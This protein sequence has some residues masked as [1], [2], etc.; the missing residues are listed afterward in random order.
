M[1]IK[2]FYHELAAWIDPLL[3]KGDA[4]FTIG[5]NGPQGCGKTTLTSALC[6]IF[7]ARG[8]RCLTVS[9]DDFYLTRAEQVKL[10]EANSSNP[11]FQQRGYPGT[12]DVELGS[13][14]LRSLKNGDMSVSIPRYEKSLHGGKGDRLPEAEWT[15]VEGTVDLVFVEG[16]M[17]GFTPVEKKK[18]PNAHFSEV[19]DALKAYVSWHRQLDA[20]LQL[21]P[22]DPHFVVDWRIEAEQKMRASG[23]AGLSDADIRAYVEKFLP[24]YE[25]YLP[26]LEK[27]PPVLRNRHRV[28][29][30]KNR[31]PIA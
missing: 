7:T 9:I 26:Q 17:L 22:E 10:A 25:T 20:F 28:V 30:G 21:A 15:Q 19:N 12:H 11:Y 29:I 3:A 14:V 18:L 6:E 31:L 24:A 8:K 13:R 27:K 16:W 4:G 5:V 1:K 23:K 2:S